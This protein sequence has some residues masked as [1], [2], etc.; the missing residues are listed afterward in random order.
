VT[1]YKRETVQALNELCQWPM[2][3]WG[4]D[5]LS[6]AILYTDA[7]CRLAGAYDD[8]GDC[9]EASALFGGHSMFDGQL[10]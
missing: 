10:A 4:T 5:L 3:F 2:R 6:W 8:N 9:A 1:T 7:Q